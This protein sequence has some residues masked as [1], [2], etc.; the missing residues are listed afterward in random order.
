MIQRGELALTNK[1]FLFI[2]TSVGLEVM[3]GQL[4]IDNRQQNPSTNKPIITNKLTNK[5]AM[6][7]NDI[8]TQSQN[9][10]D[11]AYYF[12]ELNH[13]ETSKSLIKT[14]DTILQQ[15]N[16]KLQ[17]LDFLGVCIGPGSFTGLRIGISTIKGFSLVTKL[18]IVSVNTLALNAYNVVRPTKQLEIN[19]KKIDVKNS[20]ESSFVNKSNLSTQSN[21]IILSIVD[22]SNGVYY[23]AKYKLDEDNLICLLQPT[24]IYAKDIFSHMLKNDFI[25]CDTQETANQLDCKFLPLTPLRIFWAIQSNNSNSVDYKTLEPF[26][27]R[28]AQPDRTKEDI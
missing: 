6:H 19:G 20:L 25:V 15:A 13:R 7:P 2:N 8:V 11:N 21:K 1:T 10:I 27:I 28:K 3:L 5:I 4:I 23:I 9:L 22:G 24:C 16:K 17:D 14:I 12:Y 18:P 26:Y